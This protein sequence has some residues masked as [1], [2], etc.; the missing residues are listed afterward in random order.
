MATID[1]HVHWWPPAFLDYLE[2]ADEPAKNLPPLPLITAPPVAD[3]GLRAKLMDAAGI[4][5][6]V[7]SNQAQP[8]AT[9]HPGLAEI[10]NNGLAAVVSDRFRFFASLPLPRVAE[11]LTEI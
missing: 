11:S 8:D 2:K 6:A 7:L 3:L 5:V 9:I 1:F 10:S 4:D